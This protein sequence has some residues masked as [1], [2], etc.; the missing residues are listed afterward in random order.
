MMSTMIERRFR[1]TQGA[2]PTCE[3]GAPAVMWLAG[4]APKERKGFCAS[5]AN[6]L[7]AA[8]KKKPDGRRVVRSAGTRGRVRRGEA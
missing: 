5:H 6:E 7:L 8:L 3:C 2:N 1:A 4:G